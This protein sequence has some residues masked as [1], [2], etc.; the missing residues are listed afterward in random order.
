MNESYQLTINQLQEIEA[1]SEG[2]LQILEVI[3][4]QDSNSSLWITISLRI[5]KI[6]SHPVGIQ[7]R[8][9]E[10]FRICTPAN[11]PFVK[12]EVWVEHNRFAGYPHVQWKHYLCL[13]QAPDVEWDPSD[14]MYGFISR[15]WLWIKCAALNELD[16]VGAPLHP[17]AVYLSEGPVR[18]FIPRIDTPP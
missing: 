3:E 14:G 17:P 1:A 10:K 11:F 4:P 16:P 6:P 8:T 9:R 7:F 13:Y 18:Y 5:G 2:I 15:L 12:P